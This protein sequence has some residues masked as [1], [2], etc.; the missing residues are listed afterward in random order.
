MTQGHQ[1]SSCL[2]TFELHLLVNNEVVEITCPSGGRRIDSRAAKAFVFKVS[3][4]AGTSKL[5]VPAGEMFLAYEKPEWALPLVLLRAAKDAL[6]T[7]KD[8]E[9][10]GTGNSKSLT[11]D[12][13]ASKTDE[14]LR[15]TI[16]AYLRK[17]YDVNFEVPFTVVELLT[18]IQSTPERT[19]RQ[20]HYLHKHEMISFGWASDIWE[21]RGCTE[22]WLTKSFTISKQNHDNLQL[23]GQKRDYP[24]LGSASSERN[25]EWDFFIC[26]ASEDKDSVALPLSKELQRHDAKVWLDQ[27]SLTVGDS[28]SRK[29][30]DGL[31]RSRFGIVVLSPSFFGK[32]WPERELSGLVQKE[33]D[34]AKVILPIWHNVGHE[35]IVA[36]SP[37]LA[38]RLAVSTRTGIKNVANELL[39][40]SIA[41]TSPDKNNTIPSSST[42]VAELTIGFKELQIYDQLHTYGLTVKLKLN[43]PPDQGRLRLKL[44]WPSI[45]PITK[46]AGLKMA[47]RNITKGSVDSRVYSLDWNERVFPGEEVELLGREPDYC[48]EYRFDD[49]V[50]AESRKLRYSVNYTLHLEDHRPISGSVLLED[51]HV[52]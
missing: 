27:A 2:S 24:Q 26:H 40:A 22:E 14:E 12:V 41:R 45:V 39:R 50:W 44:E 36:Y 25:V 38:D 11:E 48:L 30:D 21:D 20:L 46:T 28:L 16:I 32:H 5:S 52:Y 35:D 42:E 10:I 37:T 19:V 18:A 23:V 3:T 13:F 49:S 43:E 51:L 15:K 8:P 1:F 34:G 29:I 6:T 4:S 33:I 7:H 31:K 9:M 47:K 17:R